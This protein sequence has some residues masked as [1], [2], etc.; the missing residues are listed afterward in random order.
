[1]S[2]SL[3]GYKAAHGVG[4]K[5]Q[6]SL[7]IFPQAQGFLETVTNWPGELFIYY[8]FVCLYVWGT[9]CHRMHMY[10]RVQCE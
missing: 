6:F 7:S 1:M 9:M 3:G 8:I 10:V 5:G 2:D 4:G